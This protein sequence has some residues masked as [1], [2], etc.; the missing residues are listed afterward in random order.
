MEKLNFF[1]QNVLSGE[2]TAIFMIP[3]TIFV[4]FI[5]LSF[6]RGIWKKHIDLKERTCLDE[7]IYKGVMVSGFIGAICLMVVSFI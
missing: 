7:F 2:P 4:L 6:F 3:P 1:V 5:F